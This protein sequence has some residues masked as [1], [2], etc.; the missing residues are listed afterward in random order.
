[1]LAELAL[2]DRRLSPPIRVLNIDQL[3]RRYVDGDSAELGIVCW[4]CAYCGVSAYLQRRHSGFQLTTSEHLNSCRCD[5][6]NSNGYGTWRE[7]AKD[8]CC[9]IATEQ[10]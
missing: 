10:G 1:M 5:Y 4:H 2:Q 9:F 8:T 6:A 7:S 3:A